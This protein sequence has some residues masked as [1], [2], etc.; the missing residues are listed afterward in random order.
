[1]LIKTCV[2]RHGDCILCKT[3]LD[4]HGTLAGSVSGKILIIRLLDDT[5][6][7]QVSKQRGFIYLYIFI[8]LTSFILKFLFKHLPKLPE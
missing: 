7:L 8:Y 6:P 3:G 2:V 5:K 4:K 1:M